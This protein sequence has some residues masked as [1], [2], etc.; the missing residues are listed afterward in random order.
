MALDTKLTSEELAPCLREDDDLSDPDTEL[1]DETPSFTRS[2]SLRAARR[3]GMAVRLLNTFPASIPPELADTASA[4]DA[5][6]VVVADKVNDAEVLDVGVD[7]AIAARKGATRGPEEIQIPS[8][9]Y[10]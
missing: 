1:I 8:T 5:A 10:G 9:T 2:K 3:T 7:A 6:P 4:A